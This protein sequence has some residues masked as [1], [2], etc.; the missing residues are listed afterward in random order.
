[1]LCDLQH[2][3][4]PDKQR[5]AIREGIESYMRNQETQSKAAR[6]F[7]KRGKGQRQPES[8]KTSEAGCTFPGLSLAL[9]GSD[10]AIVEKITG[11]VFLSN[12]SHGL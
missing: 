4:E 5:E 9:G 1:M 3:A 6:S 8:P 11:N 7:R 12:P 10:L 2:H